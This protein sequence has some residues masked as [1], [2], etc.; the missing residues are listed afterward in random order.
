MSI[1]DTLSQKPWLPSQEKKDNLHTGQS[2]AFESSRVALICFLGSITALFSLFFVAYVGRMA[3]GDWRVLPEP[4]LLWINT[5]ALV[6]SSIL[7]QKAKNLSN[8]FIF[9][10]AKYYLLAAGVF[11]ILF[12]LGQFK[13]WNLLNSYGYF[14]DSNASFA[15]FYMLTGLHMVHMLGGLV[16]WIWSVSQIFKSD[17]SYTKLKSTIGSTAIYWHYLLVVWLI[18]FCLLIVT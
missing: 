16:V 10:N 11:A 1:F 13:V 17:L 2:F 15:F 7:F 5:G 9:D 6:I 14:V 8:K 3:Y 12:I 4:F 18:L